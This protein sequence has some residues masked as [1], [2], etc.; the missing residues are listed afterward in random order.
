MRRSSMAKGNQ[1]VVVLKKRGS[2]GL[3]RVMAEK[4]K[5]KMIGF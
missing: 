2:G 5:G 3:V 4:D 1:T